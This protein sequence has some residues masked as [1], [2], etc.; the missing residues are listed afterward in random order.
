MSMVTADSICT[1]ITQT[2]NASGTTTR[3]ASLVIMKLGNLF[4]ACDNVTGPLSAFYL[5]D[6]HYTLLGVVIPA[7]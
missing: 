3:A 5:L 4:V 7:G 6:D 1:A 2:V